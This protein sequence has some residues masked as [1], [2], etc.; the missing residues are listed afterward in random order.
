MIILYVLAYDTLRQRDKKL[1]S[2][3]LT[4]VNSKQAGM[5]D[6]CMFF[7]WQCSRNLST[8]VGLGDQHN[9][10]SVYCLLLAI[11][12]NVTL[13]QCNPETGFSP[14]IVSSQQGERS[15]NTCS[16]IVNWSKQGA[17]Y[18]VSRLC[19]FAFLR[20]YL[21]EKTNYPSKRNWNLMLP[22]KQPQKV[23]HVR[24]KMY[25]LY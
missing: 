3:V 22:K 8:H 10:Y 15:E 6:W 5:S 24:Y 16:G 23:R 19:R 17:I 9:T 14:N 1:T 21:T 13:S 18:S 2:L 25:V 12:W 11:H 7:G 20:K 4:L